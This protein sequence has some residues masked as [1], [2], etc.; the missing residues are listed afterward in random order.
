MIP[1][2]D[3]TE[4]YLIGILGF[5]TMSVGIGSALWRIDSNFSTLTGYGGMALGFIF[6]MLGLNGAV[7]LGDWTEGELDLWR[8]QVTLEYTNTECPYLENLSNEYEKSNIEKYTVNQI[9]DEIE[10]HYIYKCVDTR[11][12][13]YLD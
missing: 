2:P 13:W 7:G 8:D 3:L 1:Q 5:I 6:I 9:Q 12:A 11:E 10:S 4:F